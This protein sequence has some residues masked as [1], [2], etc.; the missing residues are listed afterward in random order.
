M[1]SSMPGSGLLRLRMLA[2]CCL[3]A[4]SLLGRG[5]QGM[6]PETCQ[7]LNT[8]AADGGTLP[9]LLTMLVDADKI[10]QE[11]SLLVFKMCSSLYKCN[12]DVYAYG[13]LADLERDTQRQTARK[14]TSPSV[15]QDAND[16]IAVNAC[17]D[18]GSVD[19]SG[20]AWHPETNVYYYLKTRADFPA[21]VRTLTLPPFNI[22]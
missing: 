22:V 6:S 18:F 9:C 19:G 3:A 16:H 4:T 17:A 14:Y 12:L 20:N 8:P 5:V 13:S 10:A 7:W 1:H 21:W 2:A 15:T 11:K